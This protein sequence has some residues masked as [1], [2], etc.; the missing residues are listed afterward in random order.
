MNLMYKNF[1]KKY[2]FFADSMNI[3]GNTDGKSRM[4]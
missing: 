2:Y 1:L 4:T 3:K